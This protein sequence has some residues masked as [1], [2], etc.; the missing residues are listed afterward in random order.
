MNYQSSE[1]QT[2]NNGYDGPNA[3][4]PQRIRRWR[5]FL[6][7]FLSCLAVSEIYIFQQPAIYQSQA[8]VLT[9]AATDIDQ[10]S[11]VADIQHVNIQKQILLSPDILQQTA[12]HLAQNNNQPGDFDVERL[13][14]YFQVDP[15]PET[16]L[17]HLLANGP[18]PQVLQTA[19]NGWIESYM[20]FRS[21]AVAENTDKV[22]DEI[23]QQL[24]RIDQQLK[25]KR[26]EV[27]DYRIRHNILSTESA[28]NL[29]HARL[30]GLNASLNKAS[31]EEV[32]AK[33]KYEAVLE[34]IARNE[35]L[36]PQED[37][38]TLAVLLQQAEKLRDELASIEGQY[39]EDYIQLNPKLRKVREQLADIE[40][41][42]SEKT[43][44]GQQYVLQEAEREYAAAR[45]SVLAI[46]RQLEAHKKQAA[47]Y[48]NLFAGHQ[49]MQQELLNLETLQQE[50]KQRLVDI[51]VKQREKYPQVEVIDW[52]SL[53]KRPISPDYLQESLFA[54]AASL[55]LALLT[56]LIRDYLNREPPL[57]ATAV[58]LG[59]IHLHHKP[60]AIAD[61]SEQQPGLGFAPVNALSVDQDKRLFNREEI[62]AMVEMAE[63]MGKWLIGLLF[64]GLTLNEIVS[65]KAEHLDATAMRITISEQRNIGMTG[66]IANL[67]S[68][69]PPPETWPGNDEIQAVLFCAAIDSGL[70]EPRDVTAENL[71]YTY[72]RY[73]VEQGIKLADLSKIAGAISPDTLLDL[74]R[75]SP[76]QA[77]ISLDQIDLDYF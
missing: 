8:T 4:K 1:F 43:S 25:D 6:S 5:I 47:E 50:T 23:N 11:P 58:S 29:A 15:E 9:T 64:N 67:L 27:E 14:N 10:S 21:Q 63:P 26:R 45:E 3:L 16:N 59:G 53:P 48:T 42:I 75:H 39:T 56:L 40:A 32:K 7:V 62:S 70:N 22:V 49:A 34:A 74:G 44:S 20:A 33:A 73:L 12:N 55:G 46:K 52:A 51:K 66:Q 61:A 76:R 37:S 57:S 24:Q 18:T 69:C 17:V 38:R 30:Q 36:V 13:K 60:Q 31:E 68:S 19:L 77:G 35:T 72:L 71:R 54:L 28:D 65:L 41:K 2:V